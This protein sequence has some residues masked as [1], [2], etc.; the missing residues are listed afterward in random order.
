MRDFAWADE[1]E[2]LVR[3]AERPGRDDHE[4]II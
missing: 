2:L 1:F 4:D 3:A